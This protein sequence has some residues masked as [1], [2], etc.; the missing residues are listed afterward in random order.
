MP[1]PLHPNTQPSRYNVILPPTGRPECWLYT[2]SDQASAEQFA[3]TIP[4]AVVE[5]WAIPIVREGAA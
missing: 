4:G 3:A 2:T 1:E 5:D